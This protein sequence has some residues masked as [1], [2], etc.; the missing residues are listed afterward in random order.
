MASADTTLDSIIAWH[1][2]KPD[3][4]RLRIQA[5]DVEFAPAPDDVHAHVNWDAHLS[6]LTDDMLQWDPHFYHSA[7]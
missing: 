7:R 3:F 6:G 1:L 4:F 2:Y 5:H